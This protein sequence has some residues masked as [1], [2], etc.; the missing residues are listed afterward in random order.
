LRAVTNFPSGGGDP[1]VIPCFLVFSLTPTQ[2]LRDK[3]V[4]L[5]GYER[6]NLE[7]EKEINIFD[8]RAI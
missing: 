6:R 5:R 3:A 2:D 4:R 7:R 1:R 8:V